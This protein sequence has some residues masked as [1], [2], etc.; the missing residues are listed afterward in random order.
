MCNLLDGRVE[1]GCIMLRAPSPFASLTFGPRRATP[2]AFFR[3]QMPEDE[4]LRQVLRMQAE[5][6]KCRPQRS[7]RSPRKM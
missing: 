5:V 2:P 3:L 4:V 6:D 1:L 7:T